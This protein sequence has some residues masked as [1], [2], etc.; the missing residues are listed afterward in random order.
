MGQDPLR[1]GRLFVPAILPTR[2]P[3][4]WGMVSRDQLGGNWH[5]CGGLG[6]GGNV[7]LYFDLFCN[8]ACPSCRDAL[9]WLRQSLR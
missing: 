1:A 9:K 3:F 4:C 2:L 5:G 7:R 8:P 6:L